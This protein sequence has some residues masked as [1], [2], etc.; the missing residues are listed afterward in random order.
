MIAKV[1]N[2]VGEVLAEM[3]NVSWTTRRELIDSTLVV[4]FAS[5]ML[6]V[7]VAVIDLVLSKGVSLLLK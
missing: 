6:G 4:I 2:F 7:F 3:K 1:Q 5:L